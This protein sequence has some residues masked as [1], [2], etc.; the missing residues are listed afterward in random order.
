MSENTT[1]LI[2]Q[3]VLKKTPVEAECTLDIAASDTSDTLMEGFA[4][5]AGSAT[6]GNFFEVRDFSFGLSLKE[7]DESSGST[8]DLARVAQAA[9][10]PL[11]AGAFAR[12]RSAPQDMY[13][14]ISTPWNSTISHS[15]EA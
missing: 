10:K 9:L 8:D 13:T 5:K 12:W 7:N 3:F 14:S 1:D 6:L 2:M 4:H 15:V 11:A